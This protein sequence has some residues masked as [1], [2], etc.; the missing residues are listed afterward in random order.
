MSVSIDSYRTYAKY[1]Y[2]YFN[3]VNVVTFSIGV[4]FVALNWI[5]SGHVCV[6]K[7]NS[8]HWSWSA[9]FGVTLMMM[10]TLNGIIWDKRKVDDRLSALAHT[11]IFTVKHLF[12]SFSHCMRSSDSE[13]W[14]NTPFTRESLKFR[15]IRFGLVRS[16]DD[17]LHMNL[18][19]IAE[20]VTRT[21]PNMSLNRVYHSFII[22]EI[23]ETRR[24][25]IIQILLENG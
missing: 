6:K 7:G 25:E 11:H 4:D 8:D 24:N 16:A 1:C 14:Q 3:N 20:M 15:F 22:H 5:K 9:H 23:F 18:K 10:W 21:R 17:D 2:K 13:K 19:L 12:C